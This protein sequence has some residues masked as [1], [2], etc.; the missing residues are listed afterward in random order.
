LLVRRH[1]KPVF[2]VCLGIVGNLADAEDAAQ[3]TMLRGFVEIAKL[4]NG[5]QFGPWITR[6]AKNHCINVVRRKQRFDK[7]VAEKATEPDT[8]SRQHDGL[9]TAIEKLPLEI[10]LPLVMYYLDGQ[11]VKTVAKRLKVSTSGVYLKLRT[12]VKE[13]QR[14]LAEQGDTN[15]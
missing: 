3:E 5:S 6:I 7:T 2:I 13:L 12:A 4:R 10:R 11:N 15:V 14:L 1:F 9:Q 8:R